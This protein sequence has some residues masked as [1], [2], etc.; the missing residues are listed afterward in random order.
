MGIDGLGTAGNRNQFTFFGTG[1]NWL[2]S[3]SV[4]HVE[5]IYDK[6]DDELIA[7]VTAN[8]LHQLIW[9]NFSTTMPDPLDAL[10]YLQIGM[11][12]NSRRWRNRHYAE[13]FAG[14]AKHPV[15]PGR[16]TYTNWYLSGYDFSNGFD[17]TA[18]LVLAGTLGRKRER[19]SGYF[20]RPGAR[21][22]DDGVSWPRWFESASQKTQ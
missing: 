3:P 18:D 15:D 10:N 9:S 5:F 16:R 12:G 6:A 8:S 13:H 7:S 2:D 4:D 14:R 19:Q 20:L 17:L 11:K 22:G 1:D 21:T